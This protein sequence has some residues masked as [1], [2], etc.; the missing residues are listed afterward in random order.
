MPGNPRELWDGVAERDG[1]LNAEGDGLACSALDKVVTLDALGEDERPCSEMEEG[2]FC[3]CGLQLS[4]DW[5]G[6]RG[7]PGIVADEVM[8][9]VNKG[10]DDPENADIAGVAVL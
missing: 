3:P 8:G 1:P 5:L 7:C 6:T 4:G 9:L 2:G 10:E